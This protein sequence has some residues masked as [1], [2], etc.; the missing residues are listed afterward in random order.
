MSKVL[1]I[2]LTASLIFLAATQVQAALLTWRLQDVHFDDG[3]IA[4]GFFQYDPA[5]SCA[6][7]ASAN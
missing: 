7:S 4:V 6:G 5:T 2:A 1:R 3:G